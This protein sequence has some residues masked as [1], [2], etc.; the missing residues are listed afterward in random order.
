[1]EITF[2]VVGSDRSRSE[3]AILVFDHSFPVRVGD[4]AVCTGTAGDRSERELFLAFL[5]DRDSE[6][7]GRPHCPGG[8]SPT[9]ARPSMVAPLGSYPAASSSG[10]EMTTCGV[11]QSDPQRTDLSRQ[12]SAQKRTYL[13]PG[14]KETLRVVAS[15]GSR[16]R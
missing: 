12:R 6:P 15:A 5:H 11:C 16:C 10:D 4:A 2:R 13:A 1:M 3:P 8:E 7:R 9:R 14:H